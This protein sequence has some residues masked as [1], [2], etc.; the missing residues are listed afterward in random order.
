VYDTKRYARGVRSLRPALLDIQKYPFTVSLK[1]SSF[2][3]SCEMAHVGASSLVCHRLISFSLFSLSFPKNHSF[4]F[5]V[6]D[7]STSVFLFLH[8]FS[9]PICRSLIY[10]QFH[11]S[12]S[13]YKILYFSIWFLFFWFLIFFPLIFYKSFIG[14]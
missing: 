9:W 8:F 7:I 2:S 6:I 1:A 14:F 11:R 10:F 4:T 3:L 12:I 5:F 13:I